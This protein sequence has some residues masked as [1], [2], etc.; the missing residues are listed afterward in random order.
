[1]PDATPPSRVEITKDDLPVMCPPDGAKWNMHPRVYLALPK[2]ENEVQCPY[3]G[4]LYVLVET[5]EGV[6]GQKAQAG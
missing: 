3:C 2:G 1:M 5:G 6:Q 4:A